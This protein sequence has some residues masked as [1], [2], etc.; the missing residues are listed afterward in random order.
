MGSIIS[1]EMAEANHARMEGKKNVP[2][3]ILLAQS[4]LQYPGAAASLIT[5]FSKILEWEMDVKNLLTG[6]EIRLKLRELMQSTQQQMLT[7]QKQREQEIPH[8][9][10]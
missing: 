7:A 10:V 3:M 6:E 5:S 4:H 9:Y 2:N 8:M 1:R